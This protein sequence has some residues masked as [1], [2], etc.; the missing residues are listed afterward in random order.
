MHQ[1]IVMNLFESIDF[2]KWLSLLIMLPVFLGC[3]GSGFLI[4]AQKDAGSSASTAS[5]SVPTGIGTPGV[6]SEA[7][8]NPGFY[9]QASAYPSRNGI[10]ITKANSIANSPNW[11]GIQVTVR[12]GVTEIQ[13]GNYSELYRTL[14]QIRDWCRTNQKKAMIRL[15]ERSFE[16]HIAHPPFPQ[17]IRD[18]GAW[19]DRNTLANLTNGLAIGASAPGENIVSPKFWDPFVQE[20]FLLWAEKVAEY[21]AANSEITMIQ[22]EEYST[23]GAWRLPDYNPGAIRL[24]WREFA[25][26]ITSRA[27]KALVHVNTGWSV[28]YDNPAAIQAELAELTK[29]P[30]VLGPTD[31]RKD[32]EQGS[33]TLST[34][35]GTFMFNRPDQ[36]PSGYKGLHTFVLSYEWPDYN[37][38]E[39]P[40]EHFRWA[41]VELGA[42]FIVVDPDKNMGVGGPRYWRFDQARQAV[43]DLR[44][45][46]NTHRP[47]RLP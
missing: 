20:R 34:D 32:N 18:T 38:V 16:G 7:R 26:R 11:K 4:A 13:Q 14:D 33:A 28:D 40:A 10:D 19:Y 12:W 6:G 44:G 31:L 45:T 17:Y 47:A 24:L 9:L 36:S 21:A 43:D 30:I 5:P 2:R 42:Q 22:S 27:G 25:R 37:S 3:S 39:S 46:T 23:W 1:A 15:F 29:Y 35:F 8:W 41:N